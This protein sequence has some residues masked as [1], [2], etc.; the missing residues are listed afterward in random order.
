MKKI[1][2]NQVLLIQD[3]IP[4]FNILTQTLD[5]FID[6]EAG[7]PAVNSTGWKTITFHS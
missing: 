1:S 7:A 6:D 2:K 3:M 5:K 4:I